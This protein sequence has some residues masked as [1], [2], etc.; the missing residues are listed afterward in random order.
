MKTIYSPRPIQQLYSHRQQF[1]AL[2]NK[3]YFNY[4]GQGPM[5]QM[6]I[7]GIIQAQTNIQHL[8]PFGKQVNEWIQQEVAATAA[9]IAS[10]L[11]VPRE[12]IT[13]TENV[14]SGCNIAMWGIDWRSGDHLLLSD[15][16]HPSIIAMAQEIARRFDVEVSICPLML[17][18]NEGDP[19]EVVAQ[20]LRPHTRLVAL[21][22]VLWNTGQ[23]LP[24]ARITEV[25]RNNSQKT[26]ILVDAAQSVG[27][28]PLNLSELEVDFYAFTGHKW[29]CGPGGVGGLYVKQEIR[30]NLRP[31]FIGWR[32]VITDDQCQPVELQPDGRRYEIATSNYPLYVGLKE[33]IQVHQQWGTARERYEQICR[34]SEYLWHKLTELDHVECLRS[35]PP[36][37]GL[38]SFKLD[39]SEPQASKKLVIYLESQGLL[40]RS[41]LAPDCVRA[42]VHY[43]T[44]ESEIDQLIAQIQKFERN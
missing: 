7:Q 21:S 40:T 5:P 9:T 39:T 38:V 15:C 13:L 27:M 8:G 41:I 31:T 34:N 43:F 2:N 19:A 6:A 35:S 33:A 44:L 18:L 36:E 17:T 4:G 22:H 28:L 37:S 1:P 42:C 14:T 11:N 10:E 23:V 3:T 20:H 26:Q 25:C 32:G 16:E 29:L 12:T 24:L 30:D